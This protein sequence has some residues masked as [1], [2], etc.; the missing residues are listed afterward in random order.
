MRSM[1]GFGHLTGMGFSRRHLKNWQKTERAITNV[2][3]EDGSERETWSL[4]HSHASANAKR[5]DERMRDTMPILSE[6]QIA[7]MGGRELRALS[8]AQGGEFTSMQVVQWAKAHPNSALHWMMDWSEGL[9]DERRA[10]DFD[11][12]YQQTNN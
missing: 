11:R 4:L 9:T 2:C 1:P 5:P 8:A 12:A 10:A 6:E 7:D 3:R